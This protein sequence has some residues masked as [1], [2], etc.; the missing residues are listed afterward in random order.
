VL[1]GELPTP[2]LV[3]DAPAFDR[4]IATMS[5]AL[6]G[7]RLRPHVKAHK[8]SAL[9][10]APQACGHRAFTCATPRE[11]VGLAAAGVGDDL[12]LAN[13]TIDAD[14]LAAMAALDIPVTVVVDSVATV[15]AA[16]AAGIRRCLI[17][18][19]VGLP[20]CGIAPDRAGALADHARSARLE[21]RGVMGYEGH[22]MMVSDRA[23]RRAS[24]EQ[25]MAQLRRAHADVGGDI[26]SA[27]RDRD[28]RPPRDDRRHRGAS[29]Q[30]RT[31]GQRLRPPG[32][33]VRAGA[34]RRRHRHLGEPQ[35]GGCRHR[36]QVAR[37]G[38]RQSDGDRRQGL[39]LR[40]RAP[41]VCT[42]PTGRKSGIERGSYLL[43][44]T[45][46]W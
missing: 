46:R 14:R 30:L 29:R 22:L 9:A 1:A 43:T 10:A 35:V 5:A 13:E 25:S 12:L 11:I 19:N 23:E 6:P 36:S 28:V 37:H 45:R 41:H 20:R 3:I 15:D 2:A 31:D 27:G 38:P 26:V 44:S 33:A 4:N 24:V 21:V 32:S 42:R 39:D 17:D 8:C 34:T 7:R 16:A 40:R 18:V